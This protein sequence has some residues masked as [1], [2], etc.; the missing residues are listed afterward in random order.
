MSVRFCARSGVDRLR[1]RFLPP[2]PDLR[3]FYS[4]LEMGEE[5]FS[6]K[7]HAIAD[8]IHTKVIEPIRTLP[9]PVIA[10]VNG[11]AAGAGAA[12][13]LAC[14]FRIASEDARFFLAFANIG[15]TADS[16]STYYLPRL[17]GQAKA[18]EIYL[19]KQPMSAQ[20]CLEA[21]LFNRVCTQEQAGRAHDGN[22][23]A[24]CIRPDGGVRSRQGPH[25]PLLDSRLA[26]S[27]K[28]RG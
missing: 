21:G 5:E 28:G 7:V 16:G 1:K 8:R 24:A 17:V 27:I 4:W 12:I 2:G 6:E 26:H 25:G 10:S 19:M 14:D 11:V 15:A 22:R 9:K 18:M 3:E 20:S 23:P 13:A